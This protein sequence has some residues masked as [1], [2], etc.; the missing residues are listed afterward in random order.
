MIQIRRKRT[1]A[2]TLLGLLSL[3]TGGC[4]DT[5]GPSITP[6]HPVPLPPASSFTSKPG[7]GAMVGGL[8]E[9]T[10]SADTRSGQ[11]G[12]PNAPGTKMH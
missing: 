5:D 7:K 12:S 6:K 4:Q 1:A 11:V 10:G 2:L 3:A 9:A 8:P